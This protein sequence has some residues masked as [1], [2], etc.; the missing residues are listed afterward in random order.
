VSRKFLAETY[1]SKQLNMQ[2]TAF[3]YAIVLFE[4]GML[5]TMQLGYLWVFQPASEVG[6]KRNFQF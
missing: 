2:K 5:L 4:G 1:K 6:T 3:G